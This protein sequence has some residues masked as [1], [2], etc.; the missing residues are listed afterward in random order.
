MQWISIHVPDRYIKVKMH[1]ECLTTVEMSKGLQVK[2]GPSS[3]I[4]VRFWK[5]VCWNRKRLYHNDSSCLLFHKNRKLE[6]LKLKLLFYILLFYIQLFKFFVLFCVIQWLP[7]NV[8]EPHYYLASDFFQIAYLSPVSIRTVN[9]IWSDRVSG[10]RWQWACKLD[11]IKRMA[12]TA[13]LFAYITRLTAFFR[14]LSTMFNKQLMCLFLSHSPC[15]VFSRLWFV[16]C[17]TMTNKDVNV[18][19]GQKTLAF[20]WQIQI[21]RFAGK[22]S[23]AFRLWTFWRFVK[24]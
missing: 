12:T 10:N 21:R 14:T 4:I 22:V 2:F 3:R 23:M 17:P 6:K 16:V 9:S 8:C 18:H 15:A 7:P 1:N 11:E 24:G 20:I 13:A 19:S 5:E